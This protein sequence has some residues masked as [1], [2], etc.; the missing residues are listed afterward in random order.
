MPRLRPLV[1]LAA[2]AALL[3]AGAAAAAPGARPSGADRPAGLPSNVPP[4]A[5]RAEPTLPA[6]QGWPFGEQ[7]S[8]TSGTGR[9]AGGASF[10]TD[11][12]YDDH[13][14]FTTAAAAQDAAIAS[15]APTD[16]GFTY[17]D[18]PASKNGADVFR[19]A[20]GL[21]A[22]ASYWRVDWN[23]LVDPTVPIAVWGLDTNASTQDGVRAWPAGAGVSSP[24]LDTALVVSSRK[25]FLVDARSGK[26]TDVSAGLTVDRTA[27][28]FVVR[29]PRTTLPV[30][31]TWRLRL[32]AGLSNAAGDAMAPA[33]GALGGQPAVYNASYRS[34]ASEPQQYKHG[35]A[36][37]QA[38]VSAAARTA[39]MGNYWFEDHQAEALAASDVA[40]FS[41]D[42]AWSDL[43]QRRST[44]EPLVTGYSNRWFV[45]ALDLGQ[46]V[47]ENTGGGTGDLRPNYLGRVQPFGVYVP[48]TYRPGTPMP[49]TWMLHSLSVMHNQY[50]A[51]D[52]NQV[53]QTCEE[54]NSICATTLGRGPDMWYFDEAE[55]DFWEVWNRLAHSFTLDP[56]RTV[57][58]G[59]SMGGY[60][61]YK[62]GLAHPDLFAKALAIAGPPTCGVR[63]RGDVRTG[64]NPGRC[65]DDGDTL[66][67]VGNARHVP[68]L[69]DSGMADELVPFT[70]VLEQVAGFDSRGYRYHAEYYP[71]EG[72]IPYAAKDAFARAT[73]ELG[74]TT[75]ERTAARIDYTWYPD[76]A[77]PELGLTATGVYWLPALAARSSAAGF[78]ATVRA[79]SAA[80]AEPLV[81]VVKEQHTETPGDPSPVVVTNQTWQ[82]TGFAPRSNAL[83]LELT[84]VS[85][86]T[87]DAV[88]AG[89][90]KASTVALTMTSDGPATVRID[91]LRPGALVSTKGA[92]AV[93]ADS[94]GTARLRT[95]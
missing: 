50:G 27:R 6:P 71:T 88:G 1:A 93:R 59:Y 36:T 3:A 18:G 35:I 29:V 38:G 57:I 11:F 80:L 55:V 37:N 68:W 17:P 32:A 56:E 39:D 2:A 82:R 60:G 94:A 70:S 73:S 40:P 91:G 95:G 8:R 45:S 67:L 34:V 76:L 77:R 19:N 87:V 42:L 61:S 16:G 14:A 79:H 31:G 30:A 58:S 90:A 81:D 85:A 15:L 9:L 64:S 74:R 46:G 4:A 53:R 51:L 62:L 89:L 12:L 10:W 41:Q 72:H 65:T 25:A 33:T 69:V 23:T 83:T 7:F 47:V 75:R 24:G 49:L 86:V 22:K 48:T 43:G 5:T 84:G 20:V 66:P 13:G 21:D 44:P 54:R 26:R 63:V 28:S 52:P 92:P 78:L